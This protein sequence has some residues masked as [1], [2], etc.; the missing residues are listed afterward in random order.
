V[1]KLVYRALLRLYPWDYANAFSEDM[2]MAF[3]EAC[4]EQGGG[5]DGILFVL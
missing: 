5:D 2:K 3:E 1:T 4:G